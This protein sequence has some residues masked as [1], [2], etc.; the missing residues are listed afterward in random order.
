[1]QGILPDQFIEG[2]SS[3]CLQ[4]WTQIVPDPVS[5]KN[6][7]DSN[8]ELV[9]YLDG[10]H[11]PESMEMCARWFAHFTNNDGN[12]PVCLRQPHTVRNFRKVCITVQFF[13]YR[14]LIWMCSNSF[15][16]LRCTYC[17]SYVLL[18]ISLNFLCLQILLFNCMTVRDPQRLLPCLLDTCAQNGTP[19]KLPVSFLNDLLL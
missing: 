1:M 19:I 4:G 15:F 2:L 13:P 5:S 7:K 10:A 9:F 17:C 6:D 12:Q 11:S 18:A 8:S 3:V 14:I 16:L